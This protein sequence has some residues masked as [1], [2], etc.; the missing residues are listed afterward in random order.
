MVI[1]PV[2]LRLEL[3]D[4]EAYGPQNAKAARLTYGNYNIAAVRKRVDR[5]LNTKSFGQLILHAVTI[6]AFSEG[7]PDGAESAPEDGP[8]PGQNLER[9][10]SAEHG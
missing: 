4:T 10:T 6:G 5:K 3:L 9:K 2:K 8:Q 1:Y 7:I